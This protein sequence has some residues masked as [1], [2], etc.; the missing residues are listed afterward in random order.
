MT[1]PRR[2][3]ADLR[4]D[5]RAAALDAGRDE[6]RTSLIRLVERFRPQDAAGLNCAWVIDLRGHHSYTIRVADGRCFVAAG[7]APD[8]AARLETD[9]STWVAIVDGRVDGIAAFIA[10]DLRVHGDLNLAVRLETM[11]TPGPQA[12]RLVRMHQTDLRGVRVESLVAGAG[13]PLL[14]LHGLAANKL[15]FLPTLDGLAGAF[16]VH[17]LDLP[18]FGKSDKPLPTGRRYTPA[19]FAE[20]VRVYLQRH[21]IDEAYLVGNSMGGRVATELALRHPRRVR[22]LVGL[23]PAVAFD[24][25]QRIAPLLRL[26]RT[27][28]AGVAPL[29]LRAEWIERGVASLFHDP[30]RIPS[31]NLRAAAQDV[32]R[33]LTDRGYRLAT[34]AAARRLVT[35]RAEGRRGYWRRLADLQVPSLWIFGAHD[36]L[37]RVEYAARVGGLLAG[38]H[39]QVWDDCGHVPQFEL[40]DRTNR[41]ITA[42]VE[43]VEAG[44]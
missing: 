21:R 27:Q 19:W 24:E 25:Y 20:A 13:P 38:A 43:R 4:L 11:F 16:E 26:V 36:R 22:G 3:V 1:A 29:R 39:V 31:D 12:A 9:A 34:V 23:G 28:W 8:A 32:T 14:L 33:Y 17:A 18:G 7:A 5:P 30:G 2:R 37:V 10:G 41:A 44:R 42:F 35:E 6:V 15:S 40:P